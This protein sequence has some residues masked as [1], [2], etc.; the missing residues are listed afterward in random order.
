MIKFFEILFKKSKPIK[1]GKFNGFTC[2]TD[3]TI[4]GFLE[5]G[6]YKYKDCSGT[7]HFQ[8]K[9]FTKIEIR[10]IETEAKAIENAVNSV[11]DDGWRTGDI[12]GSHIEEVKKNGKLVGTKKMGSLVVEYLNK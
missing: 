1:N 4:N 3:D 2:N 6:Y 5:S 7:I 8:N 9:P 10:K 11:L 12:A